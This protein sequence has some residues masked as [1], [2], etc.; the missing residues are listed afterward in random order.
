MSVQINAERLSREMSRRGLRA[1]DLARAAGLSA[2]TVSAA[3][4]GRA[5]SITSLRLIVVALT[6]APVLRGVDELLA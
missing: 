6:Q 4:S 3:L 1:I 5:I 2:P